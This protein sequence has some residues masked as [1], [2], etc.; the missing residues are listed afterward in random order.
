[1]SQ[2]LDE[3]LGSILEVIKKSTVTSEKGTRSSDIVTP[4]DTE[5]MG[6]RGL[7]KLIANEM[8]YHQLLPPVTPALV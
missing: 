7:E 4:P 1:M 8:M 5:T 3:K 2:E 6:A